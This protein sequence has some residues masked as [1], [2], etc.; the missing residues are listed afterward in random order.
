MCYHLPVWRQ[1]QDFPTERIYPNWKLR[2]HTCW[3]CSLAYNQE[4]YFK[5]TWST[6]SLYVMCIYVQCSIRIVLFKHLHHTRYRH[7][8]WCPPDCLVFNSYQIQLI[9]P[10]PR[11]CQRC[12]Q[13]TYF[14]MKI[15][16]IHLLLSLNGPSQN[17]WSQNVGLNSEQQSSTNIQINSFHRKLIFRFMKVKN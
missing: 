2:N 10:M 14:Y 6:L 1:H 11:D 9:W 3:Y 15:T 17:L 8:A 5:H 16:R 4:S 12:H 13:A 7:A